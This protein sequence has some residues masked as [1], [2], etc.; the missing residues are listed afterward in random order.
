MTDEEFLRRLA[1]CSLPPEAF[2]HRGHVRA[3]FLVLARTPGFG[4]ALERMRGLITA[5]AAHLGKAGLY[6]ETITVAFMALINAR[7]AEAGSVDSWQAFAA[8][9]P[10]LFD[11][12]VLAGRYDQAVLQSELARRVFILP[13]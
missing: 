10:D 2:N 5:Y 3:A 1:D 9:N 8:A 7:R 11:K 12:D 6:H 4:A 13:G